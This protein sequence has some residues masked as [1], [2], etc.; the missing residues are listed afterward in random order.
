MAASDYYQT[1]GVSKSASADEIR[2][3]YR[4]L[5]RANHPDVKKDDAAAAAK[6]KEVQT[7]YDVLG[8]EEKRKK[9]DQFGADYEQFERMGGRPGGPQGTPWGNGPQG[10]GGFDFQDLFGGVDLGDIL[11]G[12]GGGRGGPRGGG[13]RAAPKGE[14][15]QS[16]LKVPFETAARGGSV[17]IRVDRGGKIETL[18][19]KIPA[20]IAEGGVMRLAGQGEP[21]MRG[22][23]PGDLLL[24]IQIQPHAWFRR[25]GNNLLLDVPLTPAE[26]ALGS[27]IEVPTLDE[28]KFFLTVPPGTSSG[29]KLRL[30]GKGIVD[31]QTHQA[32]DQFVVI[33][34]MVPKEVSPEQRSLYEKLRELDSSPR[35]TQW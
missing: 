5:S 8:D 32:G 20:G 34:I 27:Q 24:T 1:L 29:M 30:R 2:K 10:A 6:F 7:A 14:D 3:A 12:G 25:E 19:I 11:G 23:P 22:G 16:S 15:I 26:A 9:Y 28:G 13:R 4:K 17:D 21:S 35:S 31:P 33:R 18:G